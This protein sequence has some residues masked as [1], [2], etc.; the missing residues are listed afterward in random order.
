MKS[1]SYVNDLASV[2]TQ[3]YN[4]PGHERPLNEKYAPSTLTNREVED[5]EGDP[6]WKKRIRK[7][8][9]KKKR[10]MAPTV[11]DVP[12]G[13]VPDAYEG[14]EEVVQESPIVGM[15]GRMAIPYATSAI[16]NFVTKHGQREKERRE[17]DEEHP[18]EG[19]ESTTAELA[20][21]YIRMLIDEAETDAS[22]AGAL[23]EIRDLVKYARF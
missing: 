23:A 4:H 1:P 11:A 22:A 5:D 9:Q 15:L 12:R 14:E 13:D 8:A 21:M 2:Y 17:G 10:H 16:Q 18:Y 3:M 7:L 20:M 19:E 6:D